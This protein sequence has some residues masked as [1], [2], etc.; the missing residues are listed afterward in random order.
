MTPPVEAFSD[1][2]D[3]EETGSGGFSIDDDD[4]CIIEDVDEDSDDDMVD[5]HL[6]MRKLYRDN[7]NDENNLHDQLP[8]VEEVK[9]SNAY[10]P[11]ARLIAQGHRRKLYLVIAA[12]ALGAMVLS[13][14]ITVGVFKRQNKNDHLDS[15]M[16]TSRYEEVANYIFESGV[17][18]LPS[19]RLNGTPESFACA[20]MANGDSYNTVITN[21]DEHGRRKFMER[22]VLALIY[23][24][25]NGQSWENGYDFLRPIDHC[26][27]HLQYSTPQ[28]RFLKGVQCNK[29]GF[30][31][32]IDL[33]NNNLVLAG[34]PYEIEYFIH[35]ERLHLYGNNVGGAIP[36]GLSKL[37]KL[38]SLGLMDLGLRGTIPSFLGDMVSLTTL[39]LSNN[40][41]T[42]NT[43]E[44]LK[45]PKSFENLSN[46]RVLGM[47][48]MG[49]VGGL[50]P[51]SKLQKL[52]ALYLED[53]YLTVMPGELSWPSMIELDLSNNAFHG[54]LHNH[55][56]EMT[57]LAVLDLNSNHFEGDFPAKFQPNDSIQYL[58]LHDNGVHGTIP[59]RIGFLRNLKHLD[60]SLNALEGT[61]PDTINLLTSLVSLSTA[62]NYFHEAR[63]DEKMFTSLTN[64][65]DLSLKGNA[66]SGSIPEN[67]A[68][69]TNLRSL[70]LDKNA[71]VGPIPRSFGML[72]ELV[73][74]Q[75]NRNFL[76]GTIPSELN[77]LE[78]LQI[79]LLD[80]NHL[81]GKTKELCGLSGPSLKHFTSD[82]YPSLN[83]E[84]GPEVLCLCCTLCCNDE[85]LSCNDHDWTSSYDPKARYG[86]IRT[87]YEFTLDENKIKSDWRETLLEE[88]KPP[89]SSNPLNGGN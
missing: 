74:L 43:R 75:L 15:V 40:K 71:L 45:I 6:S 3:V 85:N 32:D 14:S 9:A 7:S 59:D 20:F 24:H 86:Y 36:P 46:L 21:I 41:M 66:L 84:A 64:L 49:L 87:S 55:F 57:N 26:Q 63:L 30:V 67:L 48:G 19:L 53:N 58:S 52:E 60:L 27:W 80:K 1:H 54:D 11:T 12:A 35:L 2:P 22:Y 47:D 18:D 62:G 17:S 37:K 89:Q 70:D 88:A 29:D 68:T 42:W 23:Y 79:L 4:E 31:V 56:F 65:Q 69:L 8:S 77:R 61:L 16:R 34:I 13:V 83:S 73:V 78:K 33:S 72:K 10:L 38:K 28:G 82:C 25:S 81:E 50:W 39:A 51:I 76:S 44:D 5:N